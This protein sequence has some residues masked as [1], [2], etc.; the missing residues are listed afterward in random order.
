MNIDVKNAL[1]RVLSACEKIKSISTKDKGFRLI[2]EYVVEDIYDFINAISL[3]GAEER[4]QYFD[5]VYLNGAFSDHAF[6]DNQG[7]IPK[8][9]P[10]FCQVDCEVMKEKGVK[11]ATLFVAL[12]TELGKSYLLSKHDKKAIDA[13]AFSDYIH[14]L[15]SYVYEQ[16]CQNK[17][18]QKTASG[19]GMTH[20]N[21]IM[22]ATDSTGTAIT[23]DDVAEPEPVETLE[24]LLEQ[25]N[26][27]IGLSGVKQEVKSLISMIKMKKSEMQEG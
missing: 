20:D 3:T 13:K 26:N 5:V 24:E 9:L 19:H 11:I 1:D 12:L 18:P 10:L 14:R 7:G 25:L 15:S 16:E 8:S 17:L 21:G 4:F 2:T 27:L 22:E 6:G 23:E